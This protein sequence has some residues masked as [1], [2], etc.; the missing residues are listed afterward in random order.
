MP[1]YAFREFV[2][3]LLWAELGDLEVLSGTDLGVWAQ[4]PEWAPARVEN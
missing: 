2:S 4:K 1:E 3:G